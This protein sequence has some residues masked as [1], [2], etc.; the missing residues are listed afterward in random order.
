[1]VLPE[2]PWP[3]PAASA[4]YVLPR[5]LFKNRSTIGQ[6]NEA[7]VAALEQTGYVARSFFRTPAGGVALVTQLER[8]NDDGSPRDDPRWPA[9]IPGGQSRLD[10]ARFL[11]GLFF[12]DSGRYRVTVFII[13]DVPFS[14]SRDAVAEQQA[15][16]WLREGANVL[17]PEEAERSA[18][19]SNC[20]VLVYEFES[21]GRAVRMVG[22]Q[23][24]GRQHLE[25][26]GILALLEKPN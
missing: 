13:Q 1:M 9:T 2:F 7:I 18:E 21:D 10:L 14:Q 25:K 15:R 19:R 23:L 4:W 11:K 20:T 17:P 26:A 12:V 8:I 3:P 22:S 24:T 16:G 5:V 6:V